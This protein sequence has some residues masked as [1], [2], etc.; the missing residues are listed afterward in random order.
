[1]VIKEGKTLVVKMTKEQADT[2]KDKVKTYNKTI[3]SLKEDTIKL[4]AKID[5][6][7]KELSE[8]QKKCQGNLDSIAK[9]KKRIYDLCSK[10]INGASGVIIYRRNFTDTTLYMIDL[11]D[12]NMV[13]K[14]VYNYAPYDSREKVILLPVRKNRRWHVDIPQ[15]QNLGLHMHPH[16]GI[17]GNNKKLVW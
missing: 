10:E 3:I 16:D 13:M 17:G 7:N 6:L 4:K 5:S 12:Y 8:L 14:T 15:H 2:L 1:V 9:F 11:S